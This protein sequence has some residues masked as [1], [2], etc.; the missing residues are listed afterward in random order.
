MNKNL[1]RMDVSLRADLREGLK[2]HTME[3]R[4]DLATTEKNLA[5]QIALLRNDTLLLQLYDSR[6][7]IHCNGKEDFNHQSQTLR[8]LVSAEGIPGGSSLAA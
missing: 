1:Q 7:I 5:T 3:T 2:P 8:L 4:R 6:P